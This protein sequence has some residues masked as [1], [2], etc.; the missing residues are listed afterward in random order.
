[1]DKIE[2]RFIEVKGLKLHVAELGTGSKVVILVHGFPEIW[3]TWRHQMIALANA[4]YRAVAPDFRGYGLSDQPA[5]PE[6]TSFM[7]LVNDLLGLVNQLHISKAFLIAKDFGVRP[8]FLFA[9]LH[10]ERVRG[11][12]TLGVPYSPPVP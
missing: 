10:P 4:G 2:H 3:Y 5:H 11:V 8:A 9:L 1:M 7:D 12:I 6:T